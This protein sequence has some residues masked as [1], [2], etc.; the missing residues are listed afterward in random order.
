MGNRY[1]VD[2]K[3]VSTFVNLSQ[4]RTGKQLQA[5]LGFACYLRDYIPAYSKIA[6]PLESIKLLK[7]LEGHWLDEHQR[8]FDMLKQVLSRAPVLSNPDWD[9]PLL[10]ATDA[11]QHG[12][13]GV[14]Y[15]EPQGHPIQYVAFFSRALNKSQRNYS[16]TKRELL[17]IVSTLKA[18]R[19]Y[20]YG[21]KFLL[22]TD[23]KALTYMFTAKELPYM[24]HNWIEELLEFDFTV[25]HRPGIE[26]ILPDG[27]SRLY[28]DY[29]FFLGGD[30][31]TLETNQIVGTSSA[32]VGH[33]SV[34]GIDVEQQRSNVCP[35]CTKR[36][37]KTCGTGRCYEHCPGC[38]VHPAVDGSRSKELPV[39][40]LQDDVNPNTTRTELKEFLQDVLGKMDPGTEERRTEAVKNAHEMNHFGGHNLF[41][42]IFRNGLYWSSMKRDCN[43]AASAC[44]TCLQYNVAR[45]GF[46]PLRT[47]NATYPFDHLSM[48][49]GQISVTSSAGN[50]YFLVVVDICTRF[51]L[52]RPL[53]NKSA[54]QV[55]I[56]LYRIFTDFGIPKILQSDN[57]SEFKNKVIKKMKELCG[58]RHRFA[59]A[60]YPQANGSAEAM[61]KATKSML[62]KRVNGD[63]TEWC[64]HIP[65]IQVALNTKVHKRHHSTP[66]S[67]MFC[68]P[69]NLFQENTGAQP[70]PMSIEQIIQRNDSLIELLYPSLKLNTDA[71]NAQMIDDFRVN[72]RILKSGAY[73]AGAM[74]MKIVDEVSVDKTQPKYEGPYKVLSVTPNKNYV[75]LDSTGTLYPRN[76]SPSQLK[77]ISV[78][79]FLL[80]D[81]ETYEVEKILNHRGSLQAREYLVKWKNYPHSANEWVKATHFNSIGCIS[82]YWKSISG[83]KTTRTSKRTKLNTR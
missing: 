51:A 31:L 19:Y 79:D 45:K 72:H 36:I 70:E 52:I 42:Y 54:H 73:P 35:M 47:V 23:H 26:M 27:L 28:C 14:L 1:G 16:A 22:Y 8:A 37:K 29:R 76:V 80:E 50:N 44:S 18:F 12:I 25:I 62:K 10:V 3:K 68:R 33:V 17:A 43:R 65:S 4:P 41:L 7:S 15:Q 53:P 75:L 55:A 71:Y 74:V 34:A 57:G 58:F 30:E 78:P 61:V 64:L 67:L 69:C 21:S 48:D 39:P 63:Y 6:K 13:G 2:P 40:I 38:R 5:L 59:T 81:N 82:D 46:H 60:Y 9:L 24:I 32:N 83:D 20:L 66:F 11:S 56:S 77:L 49:L